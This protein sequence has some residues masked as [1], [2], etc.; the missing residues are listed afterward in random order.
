PVEAVTDRRADNLEVE[1]AIGQIGLVFAQVT[2]DA[3]GPRD[4][5]GRRAIDR[6]F[7]RQHADPLGALDENAIAVEQPADFAVDLRKA[8]NKG[9]DLFD[10]PGRGIVHQPADAGVAV[11]KSRAAQSFEN[12]V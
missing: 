9:A 3:A 5:P 12:V 11:R 1:I 6:L 8:A 7:F 2:G 4:G 10:E